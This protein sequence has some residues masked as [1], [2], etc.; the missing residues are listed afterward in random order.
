MAKILITGG[1]GF[2]GSQLG[3]Q[4]YKKG[5]D[6][7]LLDNMS[8]GHED[9]LT[10]NGEKFGEF[11][12][13]DVR[14]KSIFKYFKDVD[15]VYHFAGIAPLP[16]CQ[17]D[18]YE[19]ISVNVAGTANVFEAC[20]LNNIKRIIFASTSAIYENN[21]STPFKESDKTNPDLIYATTKLQCE[22]LCNSFSSVYNMDIVTLR[23]FNVYGPHQDFKRKHPPLTGYLIKSFMVG[24]TPILHSDGYQKRDYVYIDD[25]INICDIVMTH[26][27][28]KGETFNVSSGYALSVRDI[29]SLISSN[30]SNPIKPIYQEASKFWDKYPELFKGKYPMKIKRLEEEVRK[31]SLGCPSKS[32]KML[33]WKSLTPPEIGFKNSVEYA[34]NMGL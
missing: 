31:Y 21:K 1:A 29:V 25:L 8:F 33:G 32:E 22:H 14:N 20:R 34:K 30:F 15:Y 7:I 27:K 4:L 10:V 9:N 3:Y 2:I 28:A 19:A 16:N 17:S 23:F 13:D 24:E 11:I 26:N 12:L 5:H 18:P 6:I